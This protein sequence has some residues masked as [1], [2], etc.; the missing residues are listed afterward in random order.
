VAVHHNRLPITYD[1]HERA[2]EFQVGSGGTREIF[3]L[4]EIPANWSWAQKNAE[5]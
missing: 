1:H 4:V 5:G 3:G 2:Y